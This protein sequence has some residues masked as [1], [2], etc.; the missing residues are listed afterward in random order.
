MLAFLLFQQIWFLGMVEATIEAPQPVLPFFEGNNIGDVP[1]GGHSI[2]YFHYGNQF[3]HIGCPQ[4]GRPH[5]IGG[6]VSSTTLPKD[7]RL[8]A[9]TGTE[10]LEMWKFDP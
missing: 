7:M 2:I 3:G 5:I 6:A 8:G 1:H 10:M 9:G 4:M